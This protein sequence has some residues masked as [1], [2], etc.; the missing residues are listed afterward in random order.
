MSFEAK[1]R[2]AAEQEAKLQA[3]RSEEEKALVEERGRFDEFWRS[4]SHE[5]QA[6]FESEAVRLTDKF[7]AAQYRAG[8]GKEG[9]LFESVRDLILLR[10]FQRRSEATTA[11]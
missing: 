10:E 11:P 6:C 1:R 4:L 5:E 9:F 2:N 3:M 8:M 7:V